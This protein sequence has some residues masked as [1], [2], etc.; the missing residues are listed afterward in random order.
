MYC[1]PSYAHYRPES[2]NPSNIVQLALAIQPEDELNVQQIL[3]YDEGVGTEGSTMDKYAA[4]TTGKGVEQNVKEVYKF[5]VLNYHDGDEIY[6]FGF[7]R[8]AFT[9]RSLAGLIYKAGLVRRDQLQ[10]VHE[11]FE[12]YRSEMLA[13]DVSAVQFREEHGSRVNIAALCC[14]DTVGSLGNPIATGLAKTTA[15]HSFHDTVLTDNVQNAIHMMSVDE[16]RSGKNFQCSMS[17]CVAISLFLSTLADN[18]SSPAGQMSRFS[19]DFDDS[20]QDR[21]SGPANPKILL[22][23]T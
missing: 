20:P 2:R 8:G 3:I 5:L 11:A 18:E 4:L 15:R 23:I 13:D 14:F 6:L 7:S 22:G 17:S 12:L 9:V 10:F 19:A 16:D 21:H 1:E